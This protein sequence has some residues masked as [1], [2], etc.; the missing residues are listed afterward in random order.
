GPSGAVQRAARVV[1]QILAYAREQGAVSA[2]QI[3]EVSTIVSQQQGSS[4][5]KAMPV[6]EPI[7]TVRGNQ[8]RAQTS[9]QRSYIKAIDDHT[10]VFGIGPAGTGKTYLAMAK[11][12]QALQR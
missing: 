7:L 8:V 9:G 12:V 11:A 2:R 6:S 3:R 4:G 5:S 1:E 10:I